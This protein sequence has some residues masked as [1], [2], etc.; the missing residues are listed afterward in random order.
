[1]RDNGFEQR[2]VSQ[3]PGRFLYNPAGTP[4]TFAGTS[5]LIANGSAFGNPNAPGGTQAAFLQHRGS[6]SQTIN[7]PAG[8]Y[9]LSFQAAQRPRN[10]QTFQVQVDGIVVGTF[11]PAGTSYS[12]YATAG[13]TVA[14][15]QHT[16]AFVGTNPGGGDNTAF[17]DLV[18]VYGTV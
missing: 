3:G 17:L 16:I 14:A 13:F 11:T 10:S 2:D 4:W 9:S 5:G 15:G 12:P 1:V 18:N 6:I 8:T 7:L